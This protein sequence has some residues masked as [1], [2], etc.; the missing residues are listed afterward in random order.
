MTVPNVFLM[1]RAEAE[2]ADAARRQ[3]E[4]RSEYPRLVTATRVSLGQA[5]VAKLC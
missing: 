5:I 1:P 2:A 3:A 4:A